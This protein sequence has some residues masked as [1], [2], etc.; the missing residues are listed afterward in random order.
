MVRAAAPLTLALAGPGAPAAGWQAGRAH[1]MLLQAGEAGGESN[2]PTSRPEL[3]LISDGA[4]SAPALPPHTPQR[5]C[6]LRA[7]CRCVAAVC[8]GAAGTP[9]RQGVLTC[10]LLVCLFTGRRSLAKLCL[11][12]I[13]ARHTAWRLG[14]AARHS[15]TCGSVSLLQGCHTKPVSLGPL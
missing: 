15:A 13:G 9:W 2:S 7:E 8:A 1:A 3:P 5:F 14:S 6:H 12:R 10:G 4:D 11:P